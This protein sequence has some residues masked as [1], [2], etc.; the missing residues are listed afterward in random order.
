MGCCGSKSVN[1]TFENKKY[2]IP[3]EKAKK[4]ESMSIVAVAKIKV[5][6]MRIKNTQRICSKYLYPFS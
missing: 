2:S 5:R 1:Y 4:L 3:I 6:A